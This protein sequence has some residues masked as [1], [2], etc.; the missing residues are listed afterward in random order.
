MHIIFQVL[1]MVILFNKNNP[2][3]IYNNIHYY[4]G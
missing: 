2:I 3:I 1:L 4:K